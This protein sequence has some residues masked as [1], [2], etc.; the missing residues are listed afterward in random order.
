MSDKQNVEQIKPKVIDPN[1]DDPNQY[2]LDQLI[3]IIRLMRTE[4]LSSK[5]KEELNKLKGGLEE[6]KIL[7]HLRHLIVTEANDDGSL[8]LTDDLKQT[9]GKMALPGNE[10][11]LQILSDIGFEFKTQYNK[12]KLASFFQALDAKDAQNFNDK[13]KEIGVEEGQDPTQEQLDQ[14]N[15]KSLRETLAEVGITDDLKGIDDALQEKLL[16][17]VILPE[18]G[19]IR[20]LLHENGILVLAKEEF[21]KP[22]KDELIDAIRSVV[23]Q[24][25]MFN[26]M[27]F[28]TMTRL[29]SEMDQ[30]YQYLLS[31]TKTIHEAIIRHARGIKGGG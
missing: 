2:S 31:S 7:D 24:K 4:T 3:N 5:T 6:V 17:F 18:N 19:D 30:T 8:K 13:L 1:Y 9:L 11:L 23:E 10:N 29:E 28:Q 22:E 20:K 15:Y 27:A 25:Q 12:D 21:T 16:D 26:D 14:I